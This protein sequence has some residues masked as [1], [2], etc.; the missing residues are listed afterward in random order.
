MGLAP[1]ICNQLSGQFSQILV[2]EI[3]KHLLPLVAAK[4]D[5]TKAQIQTEIAQ[6]ITITDRVIKENISNICRSKV[7]NIEIHIN[8]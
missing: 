1:M 5:A 2:N 8:A 7:N 4:L 6:K 3:Q